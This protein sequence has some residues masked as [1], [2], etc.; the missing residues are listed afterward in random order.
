MS[1]LSFQGITKE[2]RNKNVLAGVSLN[3]EARERVA[4]IGDNG[5]GKTTLL[6]IAM[7]RVTPDLGRVTL[8]KGI[9]VGYLSQNSDEMIS[10]ERTALFYEKVHHLELRMRSIEK[11][12]EDQVDDYGQASYDKLTDQYARVMAEYEAIDGYTLHAEMKKIL[13]GL[14]LKQEALSI[15]LKQLSGGEKMRVALARILL[16][17]PDLLVLDEPTNH[18]DIL[19]IEW[20]ENYLIKYTGGVLIVSHDRYFLDRVTTRIAELSHGTLVEKRCTYTEFIRQ[21]EIQR[22]FFLKEQKNLRIQ[23]RDQEELVRNLRRQRKSKQA[24]SRAHEVD[25]LKAQIADNQTRVKAAGHLQK[26]NG[27][28]IRIQAHGHVSKEVAW[29][30][31]LSKSFGDV[32][33]FTDVNFHIAGGERVALI[34]PNGC[35]KTTLLNILRGLDT[36][37]DGEAKLGQWIDYA[38]LGQNVEFD[39][40]DLTLLEEIMAVSG[41]EEDQ[42]RAHLAKFQFY[43][44]VVNSKLQVL[45]GGEKVRLYLSEIMLRN[46]HCLILDEPTNHLDL[47]SREA[48]ESAINDFRGTV[49]AVSH[50]RYYLNNCVDKIIALSPKGSRVLLGNYDTYQ[51]LVNK[52][53]Q[54]AKAH[55]EDQ[56]LAQAKQ[57]RPK[58]KRSSSVKKAKNQQKQ[59]ED[60]EAQILDKEYALTQ[61]ERQLGEASH[62]VDYHAMGAL[63]QELDDLYAEYER[64]SEDVH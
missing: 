13:L 45:S 29:A 32:P 26:K 56:K 58:T 16:E 37:F 61:L 49:I 48:L 53:K 3:I 10:G 47:S 44:D 1:L 36:D 5:S 52:E 23:L 2:Y 31:N 59:L 7:G 20:L 30:K 40:M 57:G 63:T 17:S 50:D 34:G 14:G 54:E 55:E 41:F 27:P 11:Q 33:L 4:L 38:Y 43:G 62:E 21:K 9:K 35:G 28:G 25:R 22:E 64:V 18:L 8:A 51:A 12:L 24:D 15:P 60:I 39:D 42:A 6:R 46:P 19:A